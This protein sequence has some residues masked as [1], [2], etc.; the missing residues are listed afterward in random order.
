MP[1][2]AATWEVKAGKSKVGTQPMQLNE[3]LS[4][5]LKRKTIK[6]PGVVAQW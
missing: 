1:I 2:I 3:I 4:Q 6:I 5:N